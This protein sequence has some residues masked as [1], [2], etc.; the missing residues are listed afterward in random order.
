[1]RKQRASQLL[2]VNRVAYLGWVGHQNLGD[3]AMLAALRHRMAPLSL[4]P[5]RPRRLIRGAEA[6]RLGRGLFKSVMLGGGTLV[7]TPGFLKSLEAGLDR[8]GDAFTLGVGVRDQTFWRQIENYPA[9]MPQWTDLLARLRSVTVRGPLSRNTLEE[10]GLPNVRVVGDPALCLADSRVVTKRGLRHIT[11]NFGTSGGRI[12][13][14][15]EAH[16]SRWAATLV[17]HLHATGWTVTALPVWP[18]DV[19]YLRQIISDSGVDIP[20]FE[21]YL[22]LSA[23]M[24]HLRAADVVV[25]EKLHAGVLA[26]CVYTPTVMIEYRPKCRDYMESVEQGEYVHRTDALDLEAVLEHIDLLTH[27]SGAVQSRIFERVRHLDSL[28]ASEA[29][30]LIEAVTQ[31]PY[32]R[33]GPHLVRND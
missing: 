4:I 8:Y 2:P 10:A 9:L 32:P 16:V 33:V 24:A 29:R 17:R 25:A 14:G 21:D 31:M 13:G 15:D 19:Q 23:V 7:N 18:P 28:Q 11:V 20:V 1:M 3:E 26:H 5:F 30:S 22:N 12:W 6:L 27:E